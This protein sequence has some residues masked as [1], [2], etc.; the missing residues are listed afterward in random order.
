M[1]HIIVVDFNVIDPSM[2]QSIIKKT[3]FGIIQK[4]IQIITQNM[5]RLYDN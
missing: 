2:E 3:M 5:I 4:I 1:T